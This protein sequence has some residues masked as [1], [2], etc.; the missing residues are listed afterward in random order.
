VVN[1]DLYLVFG[2]IL[3]GLAVPSV[4]S[5]IIDSRAPRAA[6]IVAMIG[7]G[8][9]AIAYQKKPGGYELRDIPNA[10]YRVIGNIRL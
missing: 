7:V 3:C 10:F 1:T 5:A 2:I 9:V 8:L 6:A 4:L